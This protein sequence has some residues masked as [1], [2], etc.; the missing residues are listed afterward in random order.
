MWEKN[1]R[2][3]TNSNWRIATNAKRIAKK[4]FVVICVILFIAIRGAGAAHAATLSFSPSSGS[5]KI[6]DTF[7]VN[8]LVSTAGQAMNA[9][10]GIISFPED[11]LQATSVSKSGSII[12][13]WVQEP[14]FSNSAGTID[15]EGIVLNPGFTGS[16]GK[17]ISISFKTKVS[18]SAALSFSS[19]SILANDGKG[20][21]ILGGLGGANF[22]IAELA[23]STVAP[24]T[25]SETSP[26]GKSAK[27]PPAPI[28]YS[29]THPDSDSWYSNNNPEFKWELAPGITG[30]SVYVTDK[31][32]SNPG[33]VSD[34]LFDSKSYQNLEDGI[35]Y[36]HLKL[37]NSYGWGSI[38]H[39]RFQIDTSPPKPFAAK[40]IDGKETENPCPTILFDTYDTLSGIAYYKIKIGESD[41]NTTIEDA[42]K[43]NPYTL[44]CQ[45][46]GKKM[47]LIQAFDKAGNYTVATEELTIKPLAAPV[48]TEYPKQIRTDETFALK[49]TSV[50]NADVTIWMQREKDDARS[51][52]VKSDEKGGFTFT[53]EEKLKDGIYKIWAQAT[54]KRGAKSEVS[55]K[56]TAEVVLPYVLKIGRLAI[57]YLTVINTL[58]ILIIGILAVIVYSWYRISFWRKK[59]RKE[60]RETKE[61]VRKAFNALK[62]Q[63]EK[64]VAKMD[65]NPRLS[66]REKGVCRNLKDALRIS[67]EFIEKEISDIEKELK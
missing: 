64:E 44:P 67:E 30:V 24:Q 57:D 66:K 61:A 59:I 33:P 28:I 34:G 19:G 40:I 35:W 7:S 56:I 5:Y 62:A 58:I 15:F 8:I 36:L 21:N 2:I 12:N 32:Q 11:K 45:E 14:S 16:A 42:V 47:I 60:T 55:E 20:T 46:H 4:L 22:T 25:G 23:G 37:K 53:A 3:T 26:V 48:F 41:F 63:A 18:G 43:S 9:V 1:T 54:D 52:A 13:L 27:T 65:G 38:S 50:A 29:S 6:G 49:G 39:F 17:I 51:Y 10:S 31:P